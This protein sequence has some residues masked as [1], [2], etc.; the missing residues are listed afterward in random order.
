MVSPAPA[1]FL[2][3]W[4]ETFME[5]CDKLNCRIDYLAVHNYGKA[6]DGGDTGSGWSVNHLME[7]LEAHS[8]LY[9]GRKIWLTE[10][11]ALKEHNTTKIIEYVEELLPRLEHADFIDRYSWFYTRY[12]ENHDENGFWIDS[13][14]SLLKLDKPEL[15]IVGEAYDKPWHLE[16]YKP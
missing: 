12:Y 11:A 7:K 15:S 2:D 4:T 5:E 9:G 10:F 8:Q 1:N 16:K 13:N 14:N 3:K 6:F